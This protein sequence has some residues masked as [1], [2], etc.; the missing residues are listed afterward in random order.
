MAE[1]ILY[2]S[3]RVGD[4]LVGI[5]ASAVQEVTA[6]AELTPVPLASPLVSGLLNLRGQ[7][8]TVIDLRRCL[9][10][11]DKPAGLLPVHVILRTADGG[12]SLLVDEVGDVLSLGPETVEETPRPLPGHLRD[13]IAGAYALDGA[14]LLALNIERVLSL[15]AAESTSNG[16]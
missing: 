14:H 7:I 16:E 11:R 12:V 9:R 5:D 8:V 15:A 3:C 2:A 10:I 13:V 4:L 1:P 6:G